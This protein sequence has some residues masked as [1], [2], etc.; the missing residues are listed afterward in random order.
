[1]GTD[2]EEINR[3]GENL[4]NQF[5][6]QLSTLLYEER[7]QRGRQTKT[8][9]EVDAVLDKDGNVHVALSFKTSPWPLTP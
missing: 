3:I 7:D 1:M 8:L 2:L 6:E 9:F 5:A 4:N